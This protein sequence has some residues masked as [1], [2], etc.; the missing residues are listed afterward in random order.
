ME[1]R[2]TPWS[3]SSP[4]ISGCRAAT[5]ASF[6][7]SSPGRSG[8]GSFPREPDLLRVGEDIL[9]QAGAHALLLARP[10]FRVEQVAVHGVEHRP[11]ARIPDQEALELLG[12]DVVGAD[13]PVGLGRDLVVV[14]RGR[15]D[16]AEVDIGDRLDLVVVVEHDALVPR[17]AEVLEQHV[18]RKDSGAGELLDG[19]AVFAQYLAQP[20]LIAVALKLFHL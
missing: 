3:S 7:G 20:R 14:A 11:R 13:R 17:D 9:L 4:R 1:R 16:A 8:S 6:P 2:T 15:W 10:E 18:A 12:E 19:V 5:C